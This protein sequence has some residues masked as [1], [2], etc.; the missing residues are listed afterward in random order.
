[1]A[2]IV[3]RSAGILGVRIDASGIAA[4][5]HRSRGTPRI[6]NRLLRRVRDFADIR[7]DGTVN[8]VIAE[9]ALTMLEVD[10]CGFDTLD[11]KL[12][13]TI[14]EKFAGGP[15]GL[16]SLAAAIGEERDTIEDVIEPFL[17]QQG[18]LSCA[19]RAARTAMPK[20]WDF[21]GLRARRTAP[22]AGCLKK[23]EYD[24]LTRRRRGAKK[25][26]YSVLSASLRQELI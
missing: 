12:L 26:K 17:I 11:R 13:A 7:G 1:M 20:T 23:N 25:S 6:A 4:I 18:Y 5:A 9:A 24:F 3:E 15:V 19:R 21:L 8:A 2:Q 22:S 10:R 16:D 14:V